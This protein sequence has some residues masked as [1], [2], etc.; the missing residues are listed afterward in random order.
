[1]SNMKIACD[2]E[3]LTIEGGVVLGWGAEAVVTLNTGDLPTLWTGG[4]LKRV[5]PPGLR[6]NLA[7]WLLRTGEGKNFTVHSWKSGDPLPIPEGESWH[8]KS[9][10]DDLNGENENDR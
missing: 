9:E 2:G 3:K 8:G 5:R 10:R 6:H 4:V 7:M 1:M